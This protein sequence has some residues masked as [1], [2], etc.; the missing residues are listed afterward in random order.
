MGGWD[1]IITGRSKFATYWLV[2]KGVFVRIDFRLRSLLL[3]S[4]EY[5]V[6]LVKTTLNIPI[7][8]IKQLVIEL[9]SDSH[10]FPKINPFIF[11]FSLLNRK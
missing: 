8:N 5:L 1:Q 4:G 9:F 3:A 2:R 6:Y 7:G 11:L 10:L